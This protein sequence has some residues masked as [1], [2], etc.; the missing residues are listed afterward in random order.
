[1]GEKIGYARCS[2]EGQDLAA[3]KQALIDMGVASDRIYLDH[4]LTGR[5]MDRPGLAQALAAVRA[6]DTLVVVKLDRLARSVLDARAIADTLVSKGVTLMIGRDTYDPQSAMGRMFF[7]IIAVFAEFESDL[8]R[9]RTK[10]GMAIA[11]AKGRLKGKQP[12]LSKIQQR[13]LLRMYQSGE[14]TSA[15][16]ADMFKV[17]RSTI[18]RTLKL[19]RSSKT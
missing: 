19:L 15:E 5:T 6:G 18:Y 9:E 3:Q 13:E 17:G 12:S 16:L 11:K 4:G 10:A 14:Y 8:I 2:T 7:N 1:M